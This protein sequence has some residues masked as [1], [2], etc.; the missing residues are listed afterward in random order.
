MQGVQKKRKASNNGIIVEGI[1]NCLVRLSRCCNPVPGDQIVGYITRGRGVSVH[2]ADCPNIKAESGN[3]N[4]AQ[5]L[6]PVHWEE[7]GLG[8]SYLTGL[9]VSA[10]DRQGLL[11]EITSLLYDMKILITSLHTKVSKDQ[12]AY[13]YVTLEINS[14]EHLDMVVKKLS[15]LGGV[16]DVERCNA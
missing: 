14:K 8:S 16:F 13:V 6:I 7:K 3:E 1:D 4:S 11:A 12:I 15:R 9:Q 2:R 10:Y 5:R